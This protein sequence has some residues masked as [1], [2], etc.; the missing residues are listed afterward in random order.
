MFDI[1]DALKLAKKNMDLNSFHVLKQ[2]I[3]SDPDLVDSLMLED[4]EKGATKAIVNNNMYL[5]HKT[6]RL[7][8]FFTMEKLSTHFGEKLIDHRNLIN[9]NFLNK[10]IL[11]NIISNFMAAVINV[12]PKKYNH[13]INEEMFMFS[14]L[15]F[16]LDEKR[17]S[18]TMHFS[19]SKE[20]CDYYDGI[21]KDFLDYDKDSYSTLK[22]TNKKS[23][24]I[25]LKSKNKKE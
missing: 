16:L 15:M 19:L 18:L 11:K 4:M 21:I 14:N 20:I 5:D 3:E 24:I 17:F 6:N 22:K 13:I 23:N 8:I 2:D 7:V 1:D 10:T 9:M 12:N 25:D